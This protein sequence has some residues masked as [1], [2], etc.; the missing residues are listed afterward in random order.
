MYLA[1]DV[2]NKM[3]NI[4]NKTEQNLLKHKKTLYLYGNFPNGNT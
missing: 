2:N 4:H 1:E 3:R